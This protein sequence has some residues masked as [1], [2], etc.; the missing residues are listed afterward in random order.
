MA[1]FESTDPGSTAGTIGAKH[2]ETRLD[3]RKAKATMGIEG[4]HRVSLDGSVLRTRIGP[5]RFSRPENFV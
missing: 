3:I 1:G 2:A 5:S 4:T